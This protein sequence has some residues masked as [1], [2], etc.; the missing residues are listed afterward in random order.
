ME[1]L[2]FQTDWITTQ[3]VLEYLR[4]SLSQLRTLR[5]KKI[6]KAYRPTPKIKNDLH[7]KT[8]NVLVWKTDD[9]E[10]LKK[11]LEEPIPVE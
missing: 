3:Q 9:I 2:L 6:V 7:L 8:G 11:D 4:I 5:D 10:K 1:Q